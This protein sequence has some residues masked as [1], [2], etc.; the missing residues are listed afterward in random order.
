LFQNK[1]FAGSG[2][3]K[4][5]EKNTTWEGKNGRKTGGGGGGGGGVPE[6]GGIKKEGEMRGR[7]TEG[8]VFLCPIKKT[9]EVRALNTHAETS[10]KKKKMGAGWALHGQHWGWGKRICAGEGGG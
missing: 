1:P 8:E 4:K 10:G 7:S 3:Q 9:T 2:G 6:L 5:L